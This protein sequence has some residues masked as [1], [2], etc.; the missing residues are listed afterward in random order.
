ME[1]YTYN[2]LFFASA[3]LVMFFVMSAVVMQ[4][5]NY[6]VPKLLQSVDQNYPTNRFKGIDYS[7][8]MCLVLLVS[9]LWPVNIT[10][11]VIKA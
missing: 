2:I 8:A 4:L 1:E 3:Y 9:A 6:T 7:T 11:S 10:T 5:Y